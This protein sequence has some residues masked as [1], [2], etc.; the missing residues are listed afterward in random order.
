MGWSGYGVYD[1]DG[2]FSTQMSFIENAKAGKKVDR[3]VVVQ[4]KNGKESETWSLSDKDILADAELLKIYQNF[5]K[6]AKK[7]LDVRFLEKGADFNR[8]LKNTH[9]DVEDKLVP[10]TMVADFFLRH[11]AKMP[12]GLLNAAIKAT[13]AMIDSEHTKDF[14]SPTKRRNALKKHLEAF[15]AFKPE[16]EFKNDSIVAI[17]PKVAKPKM[18]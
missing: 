5:E 4:L 16:L 7:T 1:G 11:K 3:D 6:A 2:T 12:E 10:L 8:L 15:K 14:D 9:Y 13:E 17:K 18:G